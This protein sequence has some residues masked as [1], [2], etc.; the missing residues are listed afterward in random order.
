MTIR[1]EIM[2]VGRE[3]LIG[4]TVNT[5]AAWLA[6]QLLHLGINASRITAVGDVVGEISEAVSEAF[7]RRCTIL[8]ATGGLGPTY[9]DL[10]LEGIASALRLPKEI[11]EEAIRMVE[12]KYSSMGLAITPARKKMAF[13]PRGA[14]PLSNSVG[15]APG[16]MIEHGGALIFALPGVPR[17]MK[18][19]FESEVAPRIA[20][21]GVVFR[22][23]TLFVEGV[24]ESSIAPL[25][26]EWMPLNRGIYLKSHPRCTEPAP[27]LEIHLSVQGTDAAFL[28]EALKKGE[29]MFVRLV[30]GAGGKIMEKDGA[31]GG[32]AL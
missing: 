32:R 21:R 6:A 16:M 26:E 19:M 10:T 17:E 1:S 20:R 15:T 9:D 27:R 13:M 22:E 12:T 8:I 2:T 11:N 28:D 3:L 18:A 24:P 7:G 5:N 29:E 25:I 14:V 23:R 4:K 30:R 31:C